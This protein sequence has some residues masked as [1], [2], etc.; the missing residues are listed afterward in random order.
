[1][2]APAQE[3]GLLALEGLDGAV[4]PRAGPVSPSETSK[5][6][7]G[8]GMSIWQ[9]RVQQCQMGVQGHGLGRNGDMG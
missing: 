7:I 2:G 5:T 6:S 3:G 4:Q 9:N 1:M 8:V